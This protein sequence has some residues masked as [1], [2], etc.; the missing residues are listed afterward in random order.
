MSKN[1]EFRYG[2]PGENVV[3]VCVDKQR[4]FAEDTEWKMPCLPRA[5]PNIAAIAAAH[6]DRTLFT[7][8]IPPKSP[9]QADGMWRY[10]YER[11]SSMTMERL[12]PEM[13]DVVPDLARC[14]T[15]PHL[16]QTCLFA[17][18]R[19]R[20][21]RPTAW[22]RRRYPRPH[23]GR[24]RCLRACDRAGR[25]G[26]GLS[27]HTRDRRAL[28]FGRRDARFH[29]E[30][31]PEPV[32]P[33]GRMRHDRNPPRRL[34]GIKEALIMSTTYLVQILLWFKCRK[35]EPRKGACVPLPSLQKEK[36]S[37]VSSLRTSKPWT[38]C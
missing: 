12:D 23:R 22:R 38:T 37:W 21:S 3:H 1:D 36:S 5:L 14:A 29:D 24:D 16:R 6:A 35:R 17:V 9:G 19:N 31:L 15:C 26:L 10:Y 7:R 20:P 4:M 25:D 34:A 27:G 8:F 33:A 28:Q 2:A 18:D 30:H 32:R 11:W 13:I